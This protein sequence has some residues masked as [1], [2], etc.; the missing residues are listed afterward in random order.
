MHI[1]NLYKYSAVDCLT[2]MMNGSSFVKVKASGR[3]FRRFFYLEE[4]LTGLRW[5]PSSKKSSRAKREFFYYRY[6][7]SFLLSCD[8][9]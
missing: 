3:Q 7:L 6:I 2:D 5:M 8:S 1:L 4:D 9:S